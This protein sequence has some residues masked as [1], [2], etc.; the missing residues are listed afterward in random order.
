[1][2]RA[3]TPG[4]LWYYW[5]LD[6]VRKMSSFHPHVSIRFIKG[7][8][9]EELGLSLR[10]LVLA[11][12]RNRIPD[13]LWSIG[14][15]QYG[16]SHVPLLLMSCEHVYFDSYVFQA[17]LWA[18]TVLVVCPGWEVSHSCKIIV[19]CL[20]IIRRDTSQHTSICL[21][22]ALPHCF[23]N[24]GMTYQLASFCHDYVSTFYYSC[25]LESEGKWIVA[26]ELLAAIMLNRRDS[27]SGVCSC[28]LW[29]FTCVSFHTSDNLMHWYPLAKWE[30][31]R[32]YLD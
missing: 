27:F 30:H 2:G 13:L 22:S 32:L 15:L 11:T 8:E 3:V 19:S 9:K 10:H 28:A 14:L 18:H 20:S 17:V 31:L 24:A 4:A 23:N 6:Q 16:D 12:V 29:L 1:M 21:C 25:S 7:G 5:T 26:G